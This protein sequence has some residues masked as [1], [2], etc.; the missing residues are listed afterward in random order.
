MITE[1]EPG[2]GASIIQVPDTVPANPVPD[3]DMAAT[4][5]MA[6]DDVIPDFDFD[7][8]LN[9]FGATP[10]APGDGFISGPSVDPPGVPAAALTPRFEDMSMVQN[11]PSL[12][13]FS[14]TFNLADE[15]QT[16]DNGPAFD[17]VR[18][19]ALR[20]FFHDAKALFA[21]IEKW[22]DPVRHENR[23]ARVL[24]GNKT[25]K[26]ALLV[27]LVWISPIPATFPPCSS[28]C[29]Y[30]ADYHATGRFPRPTNRPASAVLCRLH[31]GSVFGEFT[32]EHGC[33]VS[34][35]PLSYSY[36]T[37]ISNHIHSLTWPVII[38][39][40]QVMTAV[41]RMQVAQAFDSFRK[42]CCFEIESSERIVAEV[43]RRVDNN[44]PR[45]D[46]R[47]VVEDEGLRIL[48]L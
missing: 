29:Q 26:L 27:S 43:W 9:D 39:G 47:A 22:E 40:C 4:V 13:D 6:S 44:E 16:Q 35:P 18:M 3:I 32:A 2:E 31:L 41:A 11:N 42:Q 17:Q 5:E 10:G 19:A 36:T 45:D 15:P 30:F 12:V 1:A 33:R 28:L 46:W 34:P 14:N 48:V 23:E 37:P 24:V 7:K 8:F 38:A 20:A 21:E 25:H